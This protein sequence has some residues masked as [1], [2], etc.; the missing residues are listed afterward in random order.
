MLTCEFCGTENSDTAGHCTACSQPLTADVARADVQTTEQQ[1][2][3]SMH[4]KELIYG[5]G[6]AALVAALVVAWV[7]H[8][9][10][11]QVRDQVKGFYT[12]FVEVQGAV[13]QPFWQCVTRGTKVPKDNVELESMLDAAIVRSAGGY[14]K[15]ARAKCLP[16]LEGAAA[17]FEAVSAPPMM[18]DAYA[19]FIAAVRALQKDAESYVASVELIEKELP[20]D[21]VLK[22]TATAYHFSEKESAETH[23]YD[24]FLRCAAPNFASMKSMQELLEYL[25]T[26]LKD[27]VPQAQRWRQQCYPIIESTAADKADPDYKNKVAAFSTDDRDI[28]AFQDCLKAANEKQRKALHAPFEQAWYRFEQADEALA[29]HFGEYLRN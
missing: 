15:H 12:A 5:V 27:P 13:V 22:K 14:A 8:H 16:T 28:D 4:R 6:V 20:R 1:A 19:K 3:A 29:N 7:Q 2:R 21:A 17:K 26:V 10:K 24:R 11:E 23:A 9:R 18:S 25:S